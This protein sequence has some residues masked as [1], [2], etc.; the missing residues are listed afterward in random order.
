M[1]DPEAPR[2]RLLTEV[3]ALWPR[4]GVYPIFDDPGGV[5]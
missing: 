1:S 4:P 2:E 3:G 5:L